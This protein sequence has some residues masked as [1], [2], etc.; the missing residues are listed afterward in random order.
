MNRP[1]KPKNLKQV[2]RVNVLES[3]KDMGDSTGKSIKDDLLKDT[4]EEF[5]KQL[6]GTK[7]EKKFKGDIAP[8]ESL[9][10]DE[11][12]SGKS[13]ENQRLR[14][15]IA[16][17]R[18]LSRDEQGVTEKKV[19]SLKLQLHALTEEVGQLAQATQ[20]IGEEVKLAS[21]EAPIEPGVYHIVF[22]EKLLEFIRN[23]RKKIEDAGVWLEATN[24]R[25]QKKNFWGSYKKSGSKFF[26]SSEHYLSRS[27]G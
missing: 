2:Q 16:L 13:E 10:M 23:F 9:E 15:Q 25:A 8:G 12:Y 21:M 1:Q 20:N 27:A 19:N 11:V 24:K 5:F 3:L 22:F 4:S 26:L 17:E 7:E 6:F 14:Q 18:N